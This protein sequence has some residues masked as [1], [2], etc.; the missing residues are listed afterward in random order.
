MTTR[1]NRFIPKIL[2]LAVMLMVTGHTPA[3]LI[4]SYLASDSGNTVSEWQDLTG[5]AH[6]T[7]SPAVNTLNAVSGSNTSFTQAYSISDPQ[8]DGAY[9]DAMLEGSGSGSVTVWFRKNLPSI[10]DDPYQAV[11]YET[12]GRT[13]GFALLLERNAAG[14]LSLHAQTSGG[15]GSVDL[16]ISLDTLDRSDFI[17]GTVT[18]DGSNAN[19]YAYASKDGANQ[20]GTASNTSTDLSGN[21]SAGLFSQ[22]NNPNVGASISNSLGGGGSAPGFD[23]DIAAV[24]VYNHA[25]TPTEIETQFN[26][27]V[28]IPEPGTLFL[29][30]LS[31][32][33]VLLVSRHRHAV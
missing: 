22:A 33:A 11:L 5:S 8:T 25:L 23:G 16:Y 31:A 13:K 14:N 2:I 17:Q 27:L 4:H 30:G 21:N 19:L 6:W 1:T 7:F 29:F 9:A 32:I 18:F 15:A 10:L 26:S 12:G 28:T 24:Y 3:A 20:S